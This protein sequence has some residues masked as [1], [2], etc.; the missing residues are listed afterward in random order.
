MPAQMRSFPFLPLADRFYL[1]TVLD[2]VTADMDVARDMEIFGPVFP[3]ISFEEDDEALEI[4]NRC[5]FGLSGAVFSETS[6]RAMHIANKLETATVVVNGGTDYRTP[7]LAFGGYK[8]SGIGREGVSRTLDEMTQE[9]NFVLK[10][11]FC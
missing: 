2:N 3:I 4:A 1:P 8:K 6:K 11:I 7:E 9:K 10:N 5:S